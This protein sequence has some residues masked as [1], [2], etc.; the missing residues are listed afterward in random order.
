MHAYAAAIQQGSHGEEGRG[1]LGE[2]DHND[3]VV[4]LSVVLCMCHRA[5]QKRQHRTATIK[6]ECTS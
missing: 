6:H 4:S 3:L 5:N 1:G 2:M